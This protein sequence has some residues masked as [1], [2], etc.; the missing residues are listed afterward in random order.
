[1]TACPSR[2]VRL[3]G[4]AARYS[5]I[6]VTTHSDPVRLVKVNGETRVVR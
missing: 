6:W 4:E 3:I 5:Q 1:V 2:S